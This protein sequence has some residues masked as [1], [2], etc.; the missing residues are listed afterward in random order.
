VNEVLTDR[1]R[2]SPL[3]E[4]DA[5]AFHAIWGDAEVIFWGD[6]AREREQ[7]VRGLARVIARCAAAFATLGVPR[8]VCVILPTNER[9]VRTAV[10]IGSR[11]AGTVVH[12]DL[13]HD[14]WTLTP[15]ASAGG[16][17]PGHGDRSPR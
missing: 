4:G 9:S 8:L 5:D 10:R 1:L 17:A 6:H 15:P 13:L 12:A 7:S 2:I 11:R 3:V 16:R 14:L